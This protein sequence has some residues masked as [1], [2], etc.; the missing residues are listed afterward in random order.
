LLLSLALIALP[1]RA[2]TLAPPPLPSRLSLEEALHLFRQHGLDL[3]IAE[4]TIQSAEGSLRQARQVFNPNLTYEFGHLFN[5]TAEI[6]CKDAPYQCSPN[7]HT[8]TLS[9]NNALEDLIVGKRGLR[10]SVAE[11][12]LRAARMARADAQR[13]LEFQLKSQYMQA[14]LAQDSL[15]FAMEVQKGWNKTL[16]LSNLRYQKGAISEADQAVIETAKLEADQAVSQARQALLVAKAGVAFLLGVR[17]KLPQFDVAQDLP[18]FY[19]P[20]HIAAATSESLLK[21]AF[22]LR[23]DLKAQKAQR[24]RAVASVKQARRARFP[25]LALQVGFSEAASGSSLNGNS[26]STVPPTLS[27]GISGNIPIFYQ[28]Q[29]EIKQAEADLRTQTIALEKNT[30]QVISDIGTAHANYMATR[31]LVERM[32]GRL[33]DRARLARDLIKLQYEKGA[34]SLL[35]YLVA[36]RTFIA[37]NVEYLGDLANYWTAVFQ[38]EQAVGT[39][40]RK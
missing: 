14:V 17:D 23:P 15:D 7:V 11:A 13:T 39:E 3:L 5:Y 2:E 31:E 18:R 40:L 33:L 6:V 30:A 25:D 8:L 1:A 35:D 20:P 21:E 24:E 32:E 36:Q 19:V 22:E 38:L 9:D 10:I 37:T 12:A 16:D 26:G 4:A 27:V 28:Q 29:G 34:A